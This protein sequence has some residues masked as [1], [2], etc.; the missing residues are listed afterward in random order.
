MNLKIEKHPRPLTTIHFWLSEFLIERKFCIRKLEKKQ[1]T[2]GLFCVAFS[3]P[4]LGQKKLF[5][6]W[7]EHLNRIEAK[8]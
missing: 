1:K 8:L 7:T 6:V 2:Y 5:N 4:C 3:V